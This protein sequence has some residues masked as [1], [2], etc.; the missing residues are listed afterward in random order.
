[1]DLEDAI[2]TLL[3]E[4]G[5]GKSICPSEAAKRAADGGDWRPLMDAVRE[6][7][8]SLA[9]EGRIEVT[10][11]GERVNP[12]SARGA[13]RYRALRQLGEKDPRS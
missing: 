1:M 12:S 6:K 8:R 2:L 10:Q 3:A 9:A 7:G 4:R 13:I 11:G 5:E